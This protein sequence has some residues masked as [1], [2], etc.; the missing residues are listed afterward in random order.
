MGSPGDETVESIKDDGQTD[1]SRGVIEIDDAALHRRQNGIKA[2]QQIADGECA[3]KKINAAP[4]AM[5]ARLDESKFLLVRFSHRHRASTLTPPATC[6]P[7]RATISASCGS[8]TSMREPK[9][10]RPIRSPDFTLSPG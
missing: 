1:R 5:I 7:G 6:W 2:A 4:Q 9:R 10:I 3:R 8:Q